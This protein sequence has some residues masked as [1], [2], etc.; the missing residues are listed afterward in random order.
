MEQRANETVLERRLQD[1]SDTVA[2][3]LITTGLPWGTVGFPEATTLTPLGFWS[4]P[5]TDI[6]FCPS[7]KASQ[8]ALDALSSQPL[9]AIAAYLRCA[10]LKQHALIVSWFFQGRRLDTERLVPHGLGRLNI[11]SP[12]GDTVCG[13]LRGVVPGLMTEGCLGPISS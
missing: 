11:W 2:L 13:G 3:R 7:I 12:I 5:Q 1:T 10:S 4:Q 8:K 9:R 6:P